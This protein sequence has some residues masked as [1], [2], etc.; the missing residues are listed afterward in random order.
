MLNG[1]DTNSS[2]TWR[3]AAARLNDWI[4]DAFGAERCVRCVRKTGTVLI[5]AILFGAGPVRSR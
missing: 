4:S 1:I 5:F 3:F 2:R